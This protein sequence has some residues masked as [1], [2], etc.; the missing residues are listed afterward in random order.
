MEYCCS[1]AAYC[2]EEN[3]QKNRNGLNLF[4]LAVFIYLFLCTADDVSIY[5]ESEVSNFPFFSILNKA[6]FP[7]LA[8]WA[9]YFSDAKD[10]FNTTTKS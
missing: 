7:L 10:F 6:L 5:L 4:F 2:N 3:F 8:I 1:S 9:L